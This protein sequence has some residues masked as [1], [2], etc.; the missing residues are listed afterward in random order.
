MLG[1]AF[2][3]WGL[4]A[5]GTAYPAWILFFAGP[6]LPTWTFF[7][8]GTT[9]VALL[10]VLT[11]TGGKPVWLREAA[12]R[13]ADHLALM[14]GMFFL[15]V[16]LLAEKDGVLGGLGA[17]LFLGGFLYAIAIPVWVSAKR[18]AGSESSRGAVAEEPEA[19]C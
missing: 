4:A 15:G 5:L 9:L 1:A 11:I 13:T 3:L 14:P 7:G 16:A 6:S 17:T 10:F 2:G 18:A 8:F 12:E 19:E